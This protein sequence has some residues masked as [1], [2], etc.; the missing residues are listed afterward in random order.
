MEFGI[1]AC[2]YSC[3]IDGD[4]AWRVHS[5]GVIGNCDFMSGRPQSRTIIYQAFSNN[6]EIYPPQGHSQQRFFTG[7]GTNRRTAFERP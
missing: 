6:D 3:G 4:P 7:G 2:K 5:L 1:R